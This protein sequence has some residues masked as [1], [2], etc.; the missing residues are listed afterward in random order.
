M[1]ASFHSRSRSPMAHEALAARQRLPIGFP[2][3]P[4]TPPSLCLR[5]RGGKAVP[6]AGS[7]ASISSSSP[8]SSTRGRACAR[9]EAL[10]SRHS[11]RGTILWAG[12]RLPHRYECT[13]HLQAQVTARQPCRDRLGVIHQR[14][15]ADTA[16]V[17]LS[18]LG[19][20]PLSACA[21]TLRLCQGHV[22]SFCAETGPVETHPLWDIGDPVC[23]WGSR[24]TFPRALAGPPLYDCRFPISPM[25][26]CRRPLGRGDWLCS[27]A[28]LLSQ[29]DP[30]PCRT[31]ESGSRAGPGGLMD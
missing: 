29:S 20:C 21:S 18:W 19:H 11:Y 25:D 17:R 8:V 7:K 15:D 22:L 12:L 31:L 14:P 30:T 9:P 28:D 4:D 10:I 3:P 6:R 27:G 16:A 23:I 5:R 13:R 26:Y 2:C 1:N 24:V